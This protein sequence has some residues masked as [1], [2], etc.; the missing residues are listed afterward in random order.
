MRRLLSIILILSLACA[1]ASAQ[2]KAQKDRKAKLERDI[3]ILNQQLKEIQSAMRQA[4]GNNERILQLMEEF[5]ETQQLRD[6]LARKLG[7]DVMK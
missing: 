3:A 6:T 4:M 7:S 1:A 2:T 5:R